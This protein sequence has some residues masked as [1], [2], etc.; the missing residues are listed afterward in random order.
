MRQEKGFT[1][2]EVIASLVIISIILLSFFPMLITAKKT[3]VMNV[4]KLVMIQ[5]AE[6]TLDRLQVDPFGYLEQASLNPPYLHKPT[7]DGAFTYTYINCKP[8]NCRSLYLL[9]LNDKTYYT[10]ITASQNASEK[11]SKLINIVVTIKDEAKKKVYSV[12]GYVS[13]YE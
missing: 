11:N 7:K 8:Q 2:V 1:L 9:T 3:S 12:E 5:L 6:A 4:D 13:G 10:E